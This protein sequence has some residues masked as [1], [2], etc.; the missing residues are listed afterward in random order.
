MVA[1]TAAGNADEVQAKLARLRIS[2]EELPS[3]YDAPVDYN[4]T[5]ANTFL[6]PLEIASRKGPSVL[7]LFFML[8][9]RRMSTEVLAIKFG[10]SLRTIERYVKELREMGFVV[11][12]YRQGY[13]VIGM[14]EKLATLL[15]LD[16]RRW[17][18][19]VMQEEEEDA[20]EH[21]PIPSGWITIP[22]ALKRYSLS[23]SLLRY[24]ISRG[25]VKVRIIAGVEVVEEE[26]LADLLK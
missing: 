20:G 25:K 13:Q 26:T 14:T 22:E 3:V 2:K 8:A 1:R 15:G 11:S 19:I 17:P 24:L 6:M 21:Q 16:S 23:P 7:A 4:L 12:R 18:L 10:C 9:R 5:T